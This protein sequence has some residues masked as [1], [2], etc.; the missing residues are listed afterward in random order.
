LFT[1]ANVPPGKHTVTAIVS[2]GTGKSGT[3]VPTT[4]YVPWRIM[5]LGNSITEGYNDTKPT[6]RAFLWDSLSAAGIPADFVGS[7]TG[8]F[9]DP[10]NAYPGTDQ[11][12][13][14]HWGWRVDDVLY[15]CWS[16]GGGCYSGALGL[17]AAA[18][19]PDIALVHLGTNDVYHETDPS[20]IIVDNTIAELDDLIDTLRHYN[21]NI[22]VLLAQLIPM[23]NTDNSI[24]VHLNDSI[25]NLVSRKT[26]EQSPVILVDQYT[27]FHKTNDTQGDGIHPNTS[28]DLKMASR[29]FEGILAAIGTVPPPVI[30]PPGGTFD[31]SVTVFLSTGVQD[32]G[33]VYSIG[34]GAWQG[35]TDSLHYEGTQSFTLSARTVL[36]DKTDSSTVASAYFDIVADDTPPAVTE[37]TSHDP[38]EVVVVF[39]EPVTGATANDETNYTIDGGSIDVSNAALQP[40]LVTVILT[41]E[42]LTEETSYTLEIEGILDCSIAGNTIDPATSVVF[43]YRETGTILREVWTGFSGTAVSD[44]VGHPDYPHSPSDTSYETLFETPVNI[45]DN[46]GVRMQGWVHPPVSG[47]YTFWIA[48]DDGGELWLSTDADTANKQLIAWVS[49]W[50]SSREWDKESN[51]QSS[52]ISLTAGQKYYIRALMKEGSGDDNL[53]VAWQ[54]DGGSV[55][56]IPGEYLSPYSGP[57]VVA[58]TSPN[59]GQLVDAGANVG[60]VAN[61]W[62]AGG[63]IDSVEFFDG[64]VKIGS[65][66]AS[67]YQA[68]LPGITR[69]YHTLTALATDNDG[70]TTRSAAVTIEVPWY[71]MPLGNSITKGGAP[72]GFIGGYRYFLWDSLTDNNVAF[73]FVGSSTEISSAMAGKDQDHEG[74]SGWMIRVIGEDPL[75]CDHM[76]DPHEGTTGQY[77]D[78][79]AEHYRSFVQNA[80]HAPDIVLLMIGT[81]DIMM[82]TDSVPSMG[83]RY[84]QLLDSLTTVTPGAHIFAASIPPIAFQYDASTG[85]SHFGNLNDSVI[86]ANAQIAD[87][88][89]AWQGRGANVTMVDMFNT[90]GLYADVDAGDDLHPINAGYSKMAVTWYHALKPYFAGTPTVTFASASQGVTEDA[91]TVTVTAQLSSP[92]LSDVTVPFTVSGTAVNPDDHDLASDNILI[93]AGNLSGSTSFDVVD[94]I[95]VEGDETVVV[96]MGTPVNAVAGVPSV[97]TVTIQASDPYTLSVNTTGS[98]SVDLSPP[99]GSYYASTDVTLTPNPGPGQAFAHWTGALSGRDNPAVITVDTDKTVTAAFEPAWALAIKDR[100]RHDLTADTVSASNSHLTTARAALNSNVDAYLAAIQP[101]GSFGDLTYT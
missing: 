4:I 62:D 27:G 67:P 22:R 66:T 46:Y 57:P 44:L 34:G 73:D 90:P 12:H 93:S 55:E 5:P 24:L 48:S 59:D 92:S 78:G 36:N 35:Y 40:D 60:I 88:V 51:Q 95:D 84:S 1:W 99:G 85:C 29:W 81:N 18:H 97:H 23:D 77:K 14:G 11:H 82:V 63:G 70:D 20:Q 32:A 28:G 80:D 101:N 47:N 68:T 94:D 41:T 2:T 58:V 26:T 74:H 76:F 65:A 52:L 96:T 16:L 91:G 7:R 3:S 33:I 98:G 89:A 100:I 13:E 9:T 15:G 79:I 72:D 21:S 31:D 38:N 10:T 54:R 83:R 30:T 86:S 71:I 87:T 25:P 42:I 39:S 56:I 75:K 8:T 43:A 19:D 17:W 61:A 49:E 45:M 50:T 64:A 69:G 53:A 6:Y 37:V